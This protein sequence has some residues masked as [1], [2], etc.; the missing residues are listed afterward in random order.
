M[1]VRFYGA[2][3][4]DEHGEY[5]VGGHGLKD[6]KTGIVTKV[7]DSNGSELSPAQLASQILSQPGY[8]KGQTVKLVACSAG[9]KS[10]DPKGNYAQ[11]L[12]NA[13]QATVIAATNDLSVGETYSPGGAQYYDDGKYMKFHPIPAK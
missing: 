2:L 9:A 8:T 13:L 6:P 7:R 12:A 3:Y 5:S 4:H 1:R 11:Q 10:S